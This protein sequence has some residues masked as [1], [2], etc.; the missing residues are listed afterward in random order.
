MSQTY[1]AKFPKKRISP[2][3]FSKGKSLAFKLDEMIISQIAKNGSIDEE[4]GHN[5]YGVGVKRVD[6]G[7]VDIPENYKNDIYL[8]VMFG[9]EKPDYLEIP[10]E[11]EGILIFEEKVKYQ[12]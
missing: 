11:L 7:L 10:N 2:E 12:F 4:L 1:F 9:K 3:A 5:Y 8:E 6:N